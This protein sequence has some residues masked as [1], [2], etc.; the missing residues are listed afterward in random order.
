MTYVK[1]QGNFKIGK[2]DDGYIVVN[3]HGGYEKHAHFNNKKACETVIKLVKNK[4]IPK[5][6]YFVEACR[7]L[8][9]DKKYLEKLEALT[10]L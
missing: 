6:D 10:L 2:T 3:K 9:T 1:T 8:A 7:R 4:I 5:H